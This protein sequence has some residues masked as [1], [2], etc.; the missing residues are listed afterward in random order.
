MMLT[1]TDNPSKYHLI[2]LACFAIYTGII[3]GVLFGWNTIVDQK[4]PIDAIDG[5]IVTV[6]NKET[7][8]VTY[9]RTFRVHADFIGTVHREIIHKETGWRYEYPGFDRSFHKGE[10]T[11]TRALMLPASGPNGQYILKTYVIWRPKFSL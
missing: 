9:T 6:R 7:I 4:A 11:R 5:S 10:Y 8:D 3:L 1:K 2:W